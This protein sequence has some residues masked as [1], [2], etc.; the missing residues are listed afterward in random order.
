MTTLGANHCVIS[1]NSAEPDYNYPYGGN[2]LNLHGYSSHNNLFEG[3]MGKDVA[4]D[5]RADEGSKA[6]M[7]LYNTYFRNRLTGRMEVVGPD[8]IGN[9][10]PKHY[11]LVGNVANDNTYING[12]KVN[13][14]PVDTY[15]GANKVGGSIQWGALNSSSGIPTSLYLA[16]KP[17]FLGSKPWPLF[18]PEVGS[19][20]GMYNTLPA[21]NRLK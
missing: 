18:G 10:P 16:T 20:W 1:Y 8:M 5:G 15:Q 19:D 11:T 7:G 13:D 3:N 21:Y 2:D 14:D 6:Y 4:S 17:G 9:F 12:G